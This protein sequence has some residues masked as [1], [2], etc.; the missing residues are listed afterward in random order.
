MTQPT[1]KVLFCIPDISGF[2]KF[3]AETEIAHSRHIIGELLEAVIEA[4]CTGLQV[5]EIEGDAVLFYRDGTPPPL[6][7]LVE[8]ARRMYVAFHTLLKRYEL[9][10]VCQCGA[11]CGTSGLTLK[12]V[13][14]YGAALP[15]RVH[16]RS[17]F[18]GTGVIIAH[19]LLKNSLR[20]HEYLL[21]SDELCA[22]VP[23]APG[24]P[25]LAQAA[26]AYDEL[27]TIGYKVHPLAPYR[28]Q[29]RVEPPQPFRL[30]TP[31]QVLQLTRRIGA[32]MATVFQTLIDLPGRVRWIA[33]ATRV[34]VADGQP[35]HLGTRHRCIREGND[36]ELVTSDV[37]VSEAAMELW[38]T[39]VRKTGSARFR[40]TPA[41]ADATDVS[42]TFYVRD[43]LPMRLLF[44]LLMAARLRRGF[45]RSLQNL[46]RL[47]E[48]PV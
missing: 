21:L 34:E 23:P 18:I 1:G 19:R 12:I 16:D 5:S 13:A 48:Q 26:D 36:P 39:D 10:R 14:H 30:E 43:S 40:L 2:T 35:N 22:T 46:A 11:C 4:N 44:Q 31:R 24:L 3:V 7:E 20:E 9:F 41:S 25:A 45:E 42:V 6:P 47:L 15:M 37:Q 32:P 17:K 8:Q 33:G 27:G 28:A 38:E 29:V